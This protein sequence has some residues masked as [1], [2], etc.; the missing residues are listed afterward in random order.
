MIKNPVIIQMLRWLS[1]VLFLT[2]GVLVIT[3][4]HTQNIEDTLILGIILLVVGGIKLSTY[5]LVRM[6]EQPSDLMVATGISSIILGIIFLV[7]DYDLSSLCLAWG[8]VEIILPLLEINQDIV[9]LKHNK[10][11]LIEIFISLGT[12]T[13]GI[14]LCI[15]SKE[16]LNAHLIYLSISLFLTTVY[17]ALSIIFGS[18]LRKEKE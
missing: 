10:L 8:I 18:Y 11:V 7:S 12:L 2:A 1:V 17:E 4:R 9:H 5:F 13:F 15:H 6:K 14:L 16:G 3:L